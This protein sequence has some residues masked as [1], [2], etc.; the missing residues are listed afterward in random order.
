MKV[1]KTAYQLGQSQVETPL[2]IVALLW[3]LVLERRPTLGRVLDMGSGDGRFA[4]GGHYDSYDGVEIDPA[5]LAR[6]RLPARARIHNQC[7][8]EFQRTG[9]D[10][11]IG[12][13][14]Y[15]R[16]HD[17]ESPWKQV[18]TEKLRQLTGIRLDLHGNLYLYFMTLALAKTLDDGIIALI[19]P[20][21]WV[22]RP[23][24]APLRKYL[25]EKN[26]DVLVY[27]FKNAIFPSVLTTACVTVIDKRNGTGK[28]KYFDVDKDLTIRQRMG[29]SGRKESILSHA[30][31]DSV[32]ARRGISPGAQTIFT[33][34][35]GERIHHG[36]REGDVLPCVTTLRSVP[37]DL[38]LL[39]PKAFQ[40]HFVQAGQRCWLIKSTGPL[41][42]KRVRAYL[43]SIPD[44]LRDTYTCQNQDPWYDYEWMPLPNLLVH[45]AFIEHGPKVLVN[46]VGAQAVGSVYGVHA[47]KRVSLT[48][49]QAYLVDFDFEKRIVSHAKSLKKIEVRQLNAVLSEWLRKTNNGC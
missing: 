47:D 36:L 16:H 33:L 29:I 44:S 21:E 38:R 37:H 8:F 35:E 30:P 13:P 17:I 4:L 48:H 14:P 2:P 28:W 6:L 45:S 42:S 49:L 12:N 11:C 1:T 23:S 32:W 3:R 5:S 41:L 27:R 22:S 43:D 20:F 39:S 9:F 26:F 46:S 24:S 19:V 31:R 7:V 18:V 34:T 40:K 10:A 25:C 15:V